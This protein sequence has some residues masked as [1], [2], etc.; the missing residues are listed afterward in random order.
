[1]NKLN[2]CV[3]KLSINPPCFSLY[4]SLS[5]RFFFGIK[6]WGGDKVEEEEHI[7]TARENILKYLDVKSPWL[8]NS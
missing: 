7:S 3:N 2:N 6:A 1:M 5:L 8:P 4:L